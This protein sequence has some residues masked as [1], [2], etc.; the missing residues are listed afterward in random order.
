MSQ[1]AVHKN[2]LLRLIRFVVGKNFKRKT[3]NCVIFDLLTGA[4]F[5]DTESVFS[6]L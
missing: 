5:V 1:S 6:T 2:A 3:S 4:H